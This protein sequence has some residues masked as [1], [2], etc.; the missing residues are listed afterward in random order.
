M[1][2]AHLSLISTSITWQEI[3]LN[4]ETIEKI[5]KLK[6]IFS[7]NAK[8]FMHSLK[9][10]GQMVLFYGDA[11]KTIIHVAALLGKDVNKPVYKIDLASLLSTYIGETEKNINLLFDEAEKTNA[12]LFFDEADALFGK[13]TEVK[14]AHDKFANLEIAYLLQKLKDYNGITIIAIKNNIDAAFIR[15]F[16][17]AIHFYK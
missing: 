8:P 11:T 10:K 6:K 2:Y 14:D 4:N 12:V 13:R 9:T 7:A 15:R 1:K 17:T 5:N 16:N 3:L